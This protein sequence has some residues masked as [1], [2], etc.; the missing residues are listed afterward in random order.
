MLNNPFAVQTPEDIS[1]ENAHDLF[2]DVFS[3]FHQ[4][5][6]PGHT[7]LHGP[8]GSGKSMMFRYMLPDCQLIDLKS[9]INELNYFSLYVPIKKTDLNIIDLQKLE[10]H[11]EYVL[12]EHLLVTYFAANIFEDLSKLV[13]LNSIDSSNF[14]NVD[15]FNSKFKQL[16]TFSGDKD[17]EN[18]TLGEKIDFAILKDKMNSLHRSARN[19]IN[20]ISFNT[21]LPYEDALCSYLDFLFPL[22]QNL[23]DLGFIGETCP[24]Y[25]L[26]DDADNLSLTQTKILNTWVSFRTTAHVSIKIS[27]QLNY[28]T[29]RTVNGS[30]IDSP[31]DYSEVNIATIYTS[32]KDK[33]YKRIVDI[34]EKRL[35]LYLDL[36]ISAKE[37]FPS[38]NE[39][40]KRI[41][42]ISEEIRS[43][44]SD[45]GKGASAADDVKRYARPDYIKYLK[46]KK[47]G[48]TYSYSGFLQLVSI[49]SG[50]I[51]YFLEPASK[52]Y[53]EMMS[54]GTANDIKEIPHTV[55]H[56]K[57]IEYSS[58]FLTTEFDKVF[59]NE[60]HT[61]ETLSTSDKLY[62]LI[63]ALGEMF[64]EILVSNASE[65]R[66]FSIA[67]TSRPSTSLLKVLDLGVSYGYFHE[68]T[69]G[70]K[71]GS[72][73]S[74]LYILSRLLGPY[75]KLDTT[76]FAGYKFIKAEV[77]EIATIKPKEFGKHMKKEIS[78]LGENEDVHQL[79]IDL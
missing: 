48:S 44:Y 78:K 20:R 39:Q 4:V 54:L 72:G 75:F 46:M 42:I 68:S 56:E 10:N 14:K 1:A 2:V 64:H 27:T 45:K 25:L 53:G 79:K 73:R 67:F 60:D 66:V 47:S 59:K 62:N 7:F 55:Q 16:L 70:N 69:I 77:I 40:E 38:N 26:I 30:R 32:S 22:I 21:I 51:R 19:Y 13:D 18:F 36:D 49:S 41:N 76:S 33:F 52:M 43:N 17:L 74:K 5:P 71:K 29:Y 28:K 8:R 23:R 12:N 9:K 34:V 24:I 50:I 15:K 35:K 61:P 11:A 65:R 37:F 6:K 63:N 3:D 31:H 57:I 58:E